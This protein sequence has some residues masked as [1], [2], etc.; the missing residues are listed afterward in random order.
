MMGQIVWTQNLTSRR[1]GERRIERQETYC[2]R[3][4]CCPECAHSYAAYQK[5]AEGEGNPVS[6]GEIVVRLM[7]TV[8]ITRVLEAFGKK[9]LLP[10]DVSLVR[11]LLLR[12]WL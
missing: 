3:V 2:A 8:T 7:T 11:F 4:G 10:V 12:P 1:V 9:L 6:P 5:C